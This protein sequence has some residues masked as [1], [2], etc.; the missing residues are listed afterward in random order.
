MMSEREAFEEHSLADD[1]DFDFSMI[2]RDGEY[3]VDYDAV[4]CSLDNVDD[5]C[6]RLSQDEGFDER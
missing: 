3:G 1:D 6:R 5:Y 4:S 2:L